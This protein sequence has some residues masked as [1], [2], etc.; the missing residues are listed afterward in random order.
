MRIG[1]DRV[2]ASGRDPSTGNAAG[3]LRAGSRLRGRR[4]VLAVAALVQAVLVTAALLT[5]CSSSGSTGATADGE[6]KPGQ[7][8]EIRYRAV[9]ANTSFG[10]VNESHTPRTEL[11]SSRLPIDAATTKVSTD[12]V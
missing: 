12:E 5:G 1:M 10:L 8:T 3:I 11:Y 7:P 4:S 6:A 9:T 2:F